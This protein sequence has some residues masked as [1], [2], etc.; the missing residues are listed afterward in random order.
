M[1]FLNVLYVIDSLAI[2]STFAD[3]GYQNPGFNTCVVRPGGNSSI[4]DSPAITDAFNHCGHNGKVVFLNETY[5]INTVM[6]TTGLKNF[7]VDLLGTL[8]VCNSES[9]YLRLLSELLGVGGKHFL[10]VESFAASR[11]PESG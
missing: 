7:E 9:V 5:H 6:N 4:D 1:K 2:A 8:L 11:V 3:T 10:L